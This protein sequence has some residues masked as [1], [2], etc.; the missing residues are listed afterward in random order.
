MAVL[1]HSYPDTTVAVRLLPTGDGYVCSHLH[2]HDINDVCTAANHDNHDDGPC[3]CSPCLI[4]TGR[5]ADVTDRYFDKPTG[6]LLG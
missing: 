1:E 3:D 5:A 4:A 2:H 6:L